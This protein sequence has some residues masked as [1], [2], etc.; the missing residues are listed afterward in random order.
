M[1][2]A[3]FMDAPKSFDIFHPYYNYNEARASSELYSGMPRID[4]VERLIRGNT[5][6]F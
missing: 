2:H 5:G 1:N 6:V 4:D 3:R